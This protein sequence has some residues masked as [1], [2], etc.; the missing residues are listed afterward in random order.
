ME[1]LIKIVQVL[2]SFSILVLIHEFGHF[3]FAKIFGARVDKFYLFFDPWFSIFKFKIGETQYGM[4]WVPFG[5][6]CKI[7]GMVDESMDTDQLATEPQ[8]WEY[9]SKPAWQRML[10]IV[11]GVMM[12][13]ILA[14]GIYIGITYHWGDEYIK[15]EDVHNGFAYSELAQKIGFRNGDKILSVGG[16]HIES[17]RQIPA[18]I[19]LD[20]V[21][22]VEIERN[23]Q[24]MSV[25][26][27]PTYL[28]ELLHDKNFLELRFPFVVA[29]VVPDGN[30]ALAGVMAGDSLTGVDSLPMRYFDE[31]RAAFAQNKGDSITLQLVRAGQ[32]I[33]IDMAV[34]P[35]G[36]IGAE[37]STNFPQLYNISTRKYGFWEAIPVGFE[38]TFTS[39][40][41]YLKQ[42]K[43]IA[44]PETEAY[45]SVGGIIAMGK[46]FPAEW[47]WLSFWQVTA[48]LSIMLAVLNILPIPM[49]DGGHLVFILYEMI[50]RRA[51][52][53]K[54]MERAQTVGMV[55]VFGIIILANGNDILKL[56]FS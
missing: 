31:F 33:S 48:L 37:A 9:R 51:P 43:L 17:Y 10:I 21:E 23:G 4:G 41:S 34:T 12:N 28:K 20:A 7:A 6:Y 11:G 38:R 44:S 54:F 32:P 8:P 40:G 42:L 50:T 19:I 27:D 45:K 53:Q 26:I 30:A 36:M 18:T 46:I 5:G 15:N 39:I 1:I 25:G 22:Q 3:I 55:I 14:I 24:Q 13:I 49:L 47:N 2:A 16:Q 29:G 35:E 52:S 56:I